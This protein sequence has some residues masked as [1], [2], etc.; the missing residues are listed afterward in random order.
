MFCKEFAEVYSSLKRKYKVALV[1]G[2][3]DC[4]LGRD[5]R[6]RAPKI[7]GAGK[8]DGVAAAKIRIRVL[9]FCKA[10]GLRVWNTWLNR[11]KTRR[12]TWYHPAAKKGDAR[13]LFR[14]GW[15]I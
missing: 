3:F 15:Q 13:L 5:A 6:R 14:A 9:D 2:D 12:H 11:S 10:N 1:V 8:T 7:I 4:R